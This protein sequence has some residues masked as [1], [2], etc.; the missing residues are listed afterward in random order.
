MV[1]LLIADDRVPIRQMVR[2]TA[3]RAILAHAG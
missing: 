1:T 3:I 2:S